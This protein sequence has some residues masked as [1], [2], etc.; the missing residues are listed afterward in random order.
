MNNIF[1]NRIDYGN[2][3]DLWSSPMHYLPKRFRGFFLDCFQLNDMPQLPQADD[4]VIGGGALLCS[5]KFIA[6]IVKYIDQ[7]PH[8]RLILW[9]VGVDTAL[10]ISRFEQAHMYGVREWLP[11]TQW[12]QRWL[13][14]VSVMHPAIMSAQSIT[15]DQDFLVADH[16]KRQPIAFPAKHTRI[17]NNPATVESVVKEIARHRWVIT[18]SYHVAYWATLLKRKVVVCS[19]PWQPKFDNYRHPPVL[20]EQFSWGL[21]DQAKVYSDAYDECREANEKFMDDFMANR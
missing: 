19:D 20:A 12:E 4:I 16:W 14:C 1:I 5:T 9:G 6:Q 15:A 21:L 2:P 3:G 17:T 7:V 13:P 8:Q 10:D 18:S 11:G